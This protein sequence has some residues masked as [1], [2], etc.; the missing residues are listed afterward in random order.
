MQTPIR[1]GVIGIGGRGTIARHWKREDG[2]SKVVGGADIVDT[3]VEGREFHGDDVFF[4]HYREL[5]ARGCRCHRGDLARLHARACA[6]AALEAA[7]H[8]F[9]EKPMAIT[10]EG[11]SHPRARRSG[12]A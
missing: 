11:A 7:K 9:C 10:I 8:V 1:I 2:L 6:V 3:Y 5:I 4:T 12:S